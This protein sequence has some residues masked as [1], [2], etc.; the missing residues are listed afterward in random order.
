MAGE[1]FSTRSSH[2]GA[3]GTPPPKH[4]IIFQHMR[5]HNAPRNTRGKVSRVLAGRLAIAARLDL[6]R[7]APD[8]GFIEEADRMIES[9]GGRR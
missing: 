3:G 1:N 5:V 2:T 9:A 7:G 4:G 6:Y 8:P